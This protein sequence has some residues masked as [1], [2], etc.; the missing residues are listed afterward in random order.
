MH[1]RPIPVLALI[2]A[3]LLFPA[4]SAHAIAPLL[5]LAGTEA[6][7]ADVATDAAGNIYVCGEVARAGKLPIRATRIGPGGE[8]DA[9]VLKLRPD[10]T[11]IA[12]VVFGGSDDDSAGR[13]L[14]DA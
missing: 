14:L 2:A 3:A 12:A 4:R 11:P 10:G 13:L 5:R 1:L 8:Y 7:I 6:Y 9:F